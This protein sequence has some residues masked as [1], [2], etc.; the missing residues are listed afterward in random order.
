MG[1]VTVISG[2]ERRRLW[3][4][5]QKLALLEAAFA[6]GAKVARVAAQADLRPSQIYRWRRDLLGPQ[7]MVPV[8]VTGQSSEP[9]A[10]PVIVIQVQDATVRI[11][12][13]AS[14]ALINAALRALRR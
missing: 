3:S 1:Q 2:A 11:M 9:A 14:A 5:E 12:A 8:V 13:D 4:D 6:P 10:E 7:D